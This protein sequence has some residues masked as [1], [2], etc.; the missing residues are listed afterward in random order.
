MQKSKCMQEFTA[1][2]N[3]ACLHS[4]LQEKQLM[5][6]CARAKHK[7]RSEICRISQNERND[8]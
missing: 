2:I 5:H 3:V 6:N 4:S 8:R 1:N 7:Y